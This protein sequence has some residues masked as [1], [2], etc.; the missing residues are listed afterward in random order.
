MIAEMYS[1]LYR[2]PVPQIVPY[3]IDV[4]RSIASNN[5]AEFAMCMNHPQFNIN[6]CNKNNNGYTPLMQAIISGRIDMARL[7]LTRGA[8]ANIRDS[9]GRTAL[10][11]ACER[12]HFGHNSVI[13]I[14]LDRSPDDLD[15]VD[16]SGMTPLMYAAR[17]SQRELVVR[18]LAMG[19]DPR[20]CL[21][22]KFPGTAEDIQQILQVACGERMLTAADNNEVSQSSR[23]RRAWLTKSDEW[24]VDSGMFLF[25]LFLNIDVDILTCRSA[26]CCCSYT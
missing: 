11:M 20:V 10:V 19:A 6:T 16:G 24:I 7:L 21:K 18:L 13:D 2:P 14:I 25:I 5:V 17:C 22:H 1:F 23:G 12:G 4:F 3:H 26:D 9:N 15:V 8:D